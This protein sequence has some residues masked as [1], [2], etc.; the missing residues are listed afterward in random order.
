M[1]DLHRFELLLHVALDYRLGAYMWLWV[2]GEFGRLL[3]VHSGHPT[4]RHSVQANDLTLER[5]DIDHVKTA[6]RELD[7]QYR[8]P[9]IDHI[10]D[11]EYA[12]VGRALMHVIDHHS[13]EA[14]HLSLA[15]VG[16]AGPD[17]ERLRAL[18]GWLLD[19]GSVHDSEVR[20]FLTHEWGAEQQRPASDGT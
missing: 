20:L 8:Q 17:A 10:W 13:G 16:F 15:G 11:Q 14:R 4:S 3:A 9:C 12:W 2:G 6:L 1:W 7:L 5:Q 18:F 19:L